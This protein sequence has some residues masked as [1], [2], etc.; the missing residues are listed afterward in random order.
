MRLRT[1]L[2]IMCIAV[3]LIPIGIIGGVQGFE[4]VS[5]ML[6]S[7]IIG[8]TLVVSII[9]A[10]F[11]SRPIEKLTNNIDEISRG[12]LDVKLENSEIY[13]INNLTESLNRVMASLKLAITKVGVK[14]GEIFD[15][16]TNMISAVE[17][18]YAE[19]L[20]TIAGWAWEVNPEGI[21]TYCSK[22]VSNILGYK[23]EEIVG[24]S[25]FDFMSPEESKKIRV[26]WIQ[27]SGH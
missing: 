10:H 2:V 5:I 8:V 17:E 24:K 11:I 21:Y 15:E 9:I 23:P 3:S 14:R 19:L 18:R 1:L 7:L 13:E 4:F 26:L 16:T 6:I 12:K 25:I 27:R 22:N 20:D